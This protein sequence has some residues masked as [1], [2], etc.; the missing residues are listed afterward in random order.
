MPSVCHAFH[1]GT[2]GCISGLEIVGP[3]R[4]ITEEEATEDRLLHSNYFSGRG[5]KIT[6]SENVKIHHVTAH[7]CP[8]SGIRADIFSLKHESRIL[9]Q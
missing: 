7:H 9:G 2:N 4:D 3:N 5:I 6:D 8:S 1:T